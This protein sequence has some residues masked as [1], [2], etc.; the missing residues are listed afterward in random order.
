MYMKLA[1]RQKK[2]HYGINVNDFDLHLLIWKQSLPLCFATNRAHYS[3][4]LDS[5]HPGG[6]AEMESVGLSVRRNNLG[7]GQAIDLAGELSRMKNV[8][9]AGNYKTVAFSPYLGSYL[10]C[11]ESKFP[12]YSYFCKISHELFIYH[13]RWSKS[14]CCK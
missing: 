12:Y 4:Y 14:F 5:T 8:K 2:L 11:Q 7:I 3:R 1:E 10:S 6:R 9:T 13:L